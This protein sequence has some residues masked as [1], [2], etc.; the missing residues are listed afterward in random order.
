[1][2]YIYDMHQN[3]NPGNATE[4]QLRRCC[5]ELERR[6]RGGETARAEH[7]FAAHPD[8]TTDAET[9]LDL[10]Y[11]E[12]LVR[13][14]LGAAPPADE[15]YRRF[16]QWREP[17]CHQFQ[18]HKLLA[19]TPAA[20]NGE[21]QPTPWPAHT[22]PPRPWKNNP[23]D[24]EVLDEI[25]R[26]SMG[27]V[28][29]AWQKKVR[30]VVALKV[31][32]S[33]SLSAPE[34]LARFRQEG[35]ALG[36]LVHPNIVQIFRIDE[37]EHCP[38]LVME[39]VEGRTLSNLWMETPPTPSDL[40][41][42]VC[43]VA[44]AVQFAHDRGVVHRDLRSGNVLLTREGAPKIIDFGLAKLRFTEDRI[45]MSGQVLGTPSYMSPEQA[46]G[47]SDEV[48]PAADVYALGA[49]LY[50]G[51]TGRPPFRGTTIL[52]TLRQVVEDQPLRPRR[53]RPDVPRDLETI[54]LKCLHKHPEQRYANAQALAEDL[55]RYRTGQPIQARRVSTAGRLMMWCRRKPAL[56]GTIA[57]AIVAFG[58]VAGA[59]IYQRMEGRENL[60]LQRDFAE[61]NLYR[62]LVGEARAVMQAHDTGWY[63]KALE[64]IRQASDMTVA[65]RDPAELRELAIQCIGSPN[66]CLRLHQTFSGHEGS[67]S[68]VAFSPDGK[69]LASAS[70]DKDKKVLLWAAPGVGGSSDGPVAECAGHEDVTALAFHPG[71]DYLATSSL[72]GTVR[73]WDVTAV[74][75]HSGPSL[76]LSTEPFAKLESAVHAVEFSLDGR[77]LIVACEDGAIH[78]L[79]VDAHAPKAGAPKVGAAGAGA[80]HRVLAGHTDAVTCLAVSPTGILASG[81]RDRTIRF[82]ELTSGGEIDRIPHT[83]NV[84]NTIAFQPNGVGI[85]WGEPE[86]YGVNLFNL[87]TRVS[88]SFGNILSK[89]VNQ[90][91]F[92]RHGRLLTAAR[93]GTC[94]FWRVTERM[95]SLEEVAIAGGA[96]RTVTSTAIHPA[97]TWIAAGYGDGWVRVWQFNVPGERLLETRGN[98]Q[99]AVF[100]GDQSLL[101]TYGF[102]HD[103]AQGWHGPRHEFLPPPIDALAMHPSG[104]QVAYAGSGGALIIS[105]LQE[106]DLALRCAGHQRDITALSSS[107][108]GKLLASVSLDGTAKI[109]NWQSGKCEC[110]LA[111]D[112]GSLHGVAWFANDSRLVF[113]GRRGVAAYDL[114]EPGAFRMIRQHAAP[115]GCLA[116]R[117]DLLAFSGPA[118]IVEL[119]ELSTGRMLHTLRHPIEVGPVTAL[120]FSPDGS[121]IATAVANDAVRLWDTHSGKKLALAKLSQGPAPCAWLSFDPKGRYLAGSGR[122]GARVWEVQSNALLPV[123]QSSPPSRCGRFLPDGSALL[124]GHLHNGALLKCARA[125]IDQ[126]CGKTKAIQGVTITTLP[127]PAPIVP[128]GHTPTHAV[129]GLAASPDGHWLATGAADQTVKLWDVSTRKLVQTLKGHDN[130]VWSVAFSPDSKYVASGDDA[131]GGGTIRL[132]KVGTDRPVHQLKFHKAI[133]RGLAFH[134]DQPCLASCSDDGDVCLWDLKAGKLIGVL[135]HFDEPVHEVAFRPDGRCLVAACHDRC[136]A[137]WDLS[138]APVTPAPPTRYLEGHT[139]DV[140]TVGFSATGQY[141]ASGADKGVIMLWDGQ[142]FE[143][144]TTLRGGT[145][146]IRS[147]SFS[148]DGRFLAGGAYVGPTIVW[149]LVRLRGT[150]AAMNLDW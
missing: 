22:P 89:A 10:I 134:P 16:P 83:V 2:Q 61:A 34:D 17:L 28:Y 9:A 138:A 129:W 143:R 5:A 39:Y 47:R 85:A 50:E 80:G 29:R 104:Q 98:I 120:E 113:S 65:Q 139:S 23:Q 25:A 97:G 66:P 54:C 99:K 131:R 57:L 3:A 62:A 150:L 101:A 144:I 86:I 109:W 55:Q 96:W 18:V 59:N 111:P 88:A 24:F 14:E 67:V 26:G 1:V 71:G 11:R 125:D 41:G 122:G 126:A 146:E 140:R 135:H 53:L 51:L 141:L 44:N 92:D 8:L 20:N 38:F 87:E 82:W 106:P 70:R 69:L 75:R 48:G 114:H 137:V 33:R 79:A 115:A 37:W 12:Y 118:G 105:R 142:T 148:R 4:S 49:I 124:V 107:S 103:L 123:A 78:V 117:G 74:A 45:T 133:V 19:D 76:Q 128:G 147:V 63:W 130:V 100:V 149:D 93:D 35:E 40:A 15:Y 91:R 7:F 36:R 64:N 68:S 52:D 30:R 60:R 42:I 108:D 116:V 27:V 145:K 6:L 95:K 121:S 21:E 110:N 72:D 136:I 13:C 56:A 102:L 112:I 90:V 43:S 73:L 94:R 32:L 127:T 84:P 119:C 77:L 46:A 132:W 58:M 31:I 81:S